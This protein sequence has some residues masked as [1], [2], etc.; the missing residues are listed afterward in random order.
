LIVTGLALGCADESPRASGHDEWGSESGELD[1]DTPTDLPSTSESDSD[2]SDDSDSDSD[3]DDSTDDEGDPQPYAPV[4]YSGARVHSPVTAYVADTLLGIRELGPAQADDVFMKAGASSTV[5]L[6]TLHCFALDVPD[7]DVHEPTLG[8]S[9]DYFLNGEAADTTPFD[10]VTLAAMVGK[11]A[12]W[13]ITGDPSPVEQEFAALGPGLAVVHYGANDMQQGITYASGLSSF[14]ANMSDLLDLLLDQGVIPIVFGLSRR[15]DQ[16]GADDWVPTYDAVLRGLAQARQVPYLDLRLALAELPGYG[17]AGD[18]LHLE[19]FNQGACIFTPE[20][21]AHGYNVR[22]LIALELLDRL[23]AVLI[24][25]ETTLEPELVATLAGVG[26]LDDPFVIPSLPF[27]D[28]RDSAD[29]TSTELDVY[30][31]CL[32]G[33]D[34]SGPEYVYRFDLA[35]PTPIRAAVLDR[36]GVDIDIQLLDAS[37]SEDGCIIRH[38][39]LIQLTLEPGSYAFALDTYV[40]SGVEQSG[41]Y[42]FVVHTCEPGDPDCG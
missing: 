33:T 7:L 9:L 1:D 27:T 18:G 17:L 13:A 3:T 37:A 19:A 20:G 28:S 36:E 12:S 32:S 11:T 8:P 2:T 35:E 31:G 15:L 22:N 5:S 26:D 29:S 23:H 41:A 40:A 42:T 6:N 24:A 25:G 30:T 16:P 14:H 39:T 4:L 10:R 34:E 21:L 38:D